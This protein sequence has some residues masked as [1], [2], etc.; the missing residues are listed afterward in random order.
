MQEIRRPYELLD[1]SRGDKKPRANKLSNQLKAWHIL[2]VR[3]DRDDGI[4]SW[5]SSVSARFK[6]KSSVYAYLHIYER[7]VAFFLRKLKILSK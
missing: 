2:D 7:I 4:T 1:C 6:K 5:T 3:V